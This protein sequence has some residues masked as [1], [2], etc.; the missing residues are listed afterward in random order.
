M[1]LLKFSDQYSTHCTLNQ[2]LML[3]QDSLHLNLSIAKRTMCFMIII[4]NL[5]RF[6]LF[7]PSVLWRCW[8]GGRKGIRPVKNMG[9]GGGGHWLVRMEWRPAEWSVCLPLLILCTINSR[10]SLLALAHPGDPGKRAVNGCGG[11]GGS[12]KIDK[13][14]MIRRKLQ[15]L[16]NSAKFFSSRPLFVAYNFSAT[17][18]TMSSTSSTYHLGA[19]AALKFLAIENMSR[20]SGTGILFTLDFTSQSFSDTSERKSRDPRC[21]GAHNAKFLT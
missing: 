11:G 15:I 3:Q 20:I 4:N 5:L 9:D 19:V 7:L 2:Y 13:L 6:L 8:L 1:Q 10:S 14:Q 16:F 17:F 18:A 12:E 21:V